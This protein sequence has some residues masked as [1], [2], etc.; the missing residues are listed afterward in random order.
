MD[1]SR[2]HPPRRTEKPI[3]HPPS[4][5]DFVRLNVESA[6]AMP[7]GPRP[8]D[9][10]PD[11]TRRPGF[12]EAPGYLTIVKEDIQREK[13]LVEE[14]E[15]ARR[16]AEARSSARYV[17]LPEAERLSL[18]AGL[19]ANWHDLHEEFMGYKIA[20]LTEKQRQRREYLER[21]LAELERDIDRLEA[22]VLIYNV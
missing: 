5:T 17:E 1:K 15:A 22:R 8:V 3:R 7:P 13:T 16:A 9:E 14:T 2:P 19:K 4:E 10:P 20:G 18:L 21:R 12:G 6:K 11:P